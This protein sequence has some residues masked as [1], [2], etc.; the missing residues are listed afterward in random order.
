MADMTDCLLKNSSVA[1]SGLFRCDGD[2]LSG[3]I[4]VRRTSPFE[5]DYLQGK[6]GATPILGDMERIF[7]ERC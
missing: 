7:K 2:I 4:Q 1:F 5:K 3:R 6:Y